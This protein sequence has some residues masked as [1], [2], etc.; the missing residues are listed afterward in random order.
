MDFDEWWQRRGRLIDPEP[1]ASWED[2]RRDLA[3]EAFAAS[4]AQ[5]GNYVADT[6]EAPHEVTFANGR[7][8]KVGDDGSLTV[9]WSR[10]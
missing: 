1:N 6:A 9:G 2:K 5:S 7:T 10:T 8:V 4:K 3:A